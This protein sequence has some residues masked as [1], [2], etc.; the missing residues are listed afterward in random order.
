VKVV[1]VLQFEEY[2]RGVFRPYLHK[3]GDLYVTYAEDQPDPEVRVSHC[4]DELCNCIRSVRWKDVE[5][6]FSSSFS[7]PSVER[8][9]EALNHILFEV[10]YQGNR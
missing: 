2:P 5:Q 4:G 10:Q 3:P 9:R 6:Y 1:M 7:A 8:L